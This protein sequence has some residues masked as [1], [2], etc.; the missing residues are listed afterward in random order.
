[1]LN[2]RTVGTNGEER[3]LS[4]LQDHNVRI[5]DQNYR[6]R[7]G[8]IDLILKDR[9]YLVFLEVKY[10]K[11][12]CLGAPQEAVTLRKQKTICGLITRVREAGG[13]FQFL[14]G[15]V[16]NNPIGLII[17]ALG[18]IIPLLIDLEQRFHIFSNAVEWIKNAFP[19]RR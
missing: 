10:R 15:V 9:S 14:A 18:F 17:T 13:A 8:E 19:Y 2:K 7:C 12:S 5:L 3:A 11:N 4:F 16:R 6:N 1:M